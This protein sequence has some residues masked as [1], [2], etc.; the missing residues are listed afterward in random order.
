MGFSE[1]AHYPYH[2]VNVEKDGV[3]V[4]P[5]FS[6]RKPLP[7]D[8]EILEAIYDR[9]YPEFARGAK[10]A[11]PLH[12]NVD[13][14]ALRESKVYVPIDIAAIAQGLSVDGDLVFGRL[15]YHLENKYGYQRG[16]DDA[17]VPFFTLR[18]GNAT[19]CVNFPYMAAVLA[20]LRDEHGKFQWSNGV[21]LVSLLVSIVA[22]VVAG[23]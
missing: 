14:T 15:Y 5:L 16:E 19:H 2:L 3:W 7:T 1:L 20:D 17:K 11:P 21:A 12:G 18:A 4:M 6:H 22:L 23:K 13:T 9:Y 8:L 10:D